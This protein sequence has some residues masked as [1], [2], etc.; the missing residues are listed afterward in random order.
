MVSGRKGAEL[1]LFE[2]MPRG[3][4]RI[5]DKHRKAV[6]IHL[7]RKE[8]LADDANIRE[9]REARDEFPDT[10]MIVAHLGRSFTPYYLQE[11]LR[12]IG[13][14]S[15]FF[16]DLSAVMN[17]KVLDIAFSRI[18][19]RNL[20]YGSDMP[21]LL[22]HGT[23]QWTEKTY[24]NLAREDF[25]WSRNHRSPEE[26]ARY[27]FFMYEQ[28]SNILDAMDRLGIS[29]ADRQGFFA[30]NALRALRLSRPGRRGEAD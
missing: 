26:E 14:L 22:W 18:P 16:F 13:D 12:K 6:M 29:T 20:L 23:R 7:P 1:S 11:G 25:T 30:G 8:R 15:G 19:L 21:I 24:T 3:Q 5:A 2:F 4:W 28:L 9:L 10:T 27:T 17:P